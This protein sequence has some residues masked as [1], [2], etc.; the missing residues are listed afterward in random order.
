MRDSIHQRYEEW[1]L[2]ALLAK[3]PDLR[4]H[5]SGG[6]DLV[7]AGSVAFRVAA[8]NG[9]IIEDAYSV[10]LS[11][12]P[13]FPSTNPRAYECDARIPYDYH[14]LE[15][16]YLCLGAPTALRMTLTLSP[17]LLTFLEVLVIPYLAGY[18]YFALHGETLYG[19]LDH[20]SAGIR[21]Y[22]GELFHS[23]T[24]EWCEEFVRLASLKK[25]NAN[26][27][28]CPC[29]SGRRLGKCHNRIVN[30]LRKRLGRKWFQQEYRQIL[31]L[32]P[33]A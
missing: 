18:S 27:L 7:L 14:K 23:K 32:L 33:A 26:K 3:Y 1:E 10:E 8:P 28:P 5:A 30:A 4:V 15:G 13:G 11:I 21:Q 31:R 22:L 2:G 17:T 12:P 16:N 24:T 6:N 9:V 20:G 25:R 29:L 19:E